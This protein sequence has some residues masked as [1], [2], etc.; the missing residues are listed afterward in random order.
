MTDAEHMIGEGI[1]PAGTPW[2]LTVR[3]GRDEMPVV[4]VRFGSDLDSWYGKGSWS[5]AEVVEPTFLN[6]GAQDE[7]VL[8]GE[9][10]PAVAEV[11]VR[12]D[13]GDEVRTEILRCEIARNDYF[14]ACLGRG[15]WPTVV[16]AFD[17]HGLV[18]RER[19]TPEWD[20]G[21]AIQIAETQ[22]AALRESDHETLVSRY[23]GEIETET[24]KGRSGIAYEVETR[25]RWEN[26][27][28]GDLRVAVIVDGTH[29]ALPLLR[30]FV[31]SAD[32]RE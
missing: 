4:R 14:L 16:T 24:V 18:L 17:H 25:A 15:R 9:V 19:P 10:A 12:L 23:L 29:P 28:G 26:S 13:N 11:R 27:P 6:W 21:E 20:P 2:S 5:T 22:R 7:H 32:L 31:V 3:I 30:D 8:I 1:S